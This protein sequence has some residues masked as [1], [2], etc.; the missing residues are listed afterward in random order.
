MALT[1]AY[2]TLAA[3]QDVSKNTRAA[4]APRLERA[5]NAASRAIDRYTGR[6]FWLDAVATTRTFSVP[7][8]TYTISVPD[9][10]VRAGVSVATGPGD[11]TFPTAIS[12]S[13]FYLAPL[14]S[15]QPD[16]IAEPFTSI[17]A[18]N[19]PF[20]SSR[21]LTARS[22]PTVQVTARFGWPDA[23]VTTGVAAAPDDVVEACLL[24][25]HRIVRRKDT[26]D[27]V[28]GNDDTGVI[29]ITRRDGDVV[30]LLDPLVRM[31]GRNGQTGIA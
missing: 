1:N 18:T 15:D 7:V 24:M 9:I 5:L 2:A 20:L 17:V 11:G 13:A 30:D 22:G 3:L 26:P 16:P 6:R 12:A 4:D 21:F 8:A 14:D 25:A 19:A 31:D 29:R 28:A 27:G 23:I 10:G